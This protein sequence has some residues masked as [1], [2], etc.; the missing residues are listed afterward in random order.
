LFGLLTFRS[1]MPEKRKSWHWLI[2]LAVAAAAFALD[3]LVETDREKVDALIGTIMQAVEEENCALID[4]TI[5]EDYRDS[6][7]STKADLIRHCRRSLSRPLIMKNIERSRLVR[8]SV[9][10]ATATV[11]TTIHFEPS[12]WVAQEY[13]S[14][15]FFKGRLHFQKQPDNSWVITRITPLTVD[16]QPVKWAQIR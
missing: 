14:F 4:T 5:A 7:H 1:V 13:K 9:P 2:P 12:S 16:R 6:F 10:T 3:Y 15:I 8:M 11:W